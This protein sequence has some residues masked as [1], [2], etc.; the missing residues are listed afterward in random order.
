MKVEKKKPYTKPILHVYGTIQAI[1][2][3]SMGTNT[4]DGTNPPAANKT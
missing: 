2:G 1:T 3:A 4:R